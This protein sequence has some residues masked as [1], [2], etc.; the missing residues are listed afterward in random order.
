MAPYQLA[1]EFVNLRWGTMMPIAVMFNSNVVQ[2]R[3]RENFSA[4]VADPAR[5]SA[6]IPD[7]ENIA[8]FLQSFA[9]ITITDM[10]GMQSSSAP[11]VRQLTTITAQTVQTFQAE[12]DSKFKSI[13][14]KLKDASID[15]I[16][17]V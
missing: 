12:F 6:E 14:L 2:L 16:E 9:V 13:G 15:A 8:S 4:I 17:S 3:A 5:L 1:Q 11:D 7:P 10:I